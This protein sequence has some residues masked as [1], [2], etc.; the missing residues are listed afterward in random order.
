MSAV[1]MLII[2]EQ[3]R[4]VRKNALFVRVQ[5]K[6][7][8][9]C[10]VGTQLAA[11]TVC[12]LDKYALCARPQLRKSSKFLQLDYTIICMLCYLIY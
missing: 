5:I 8:L 10:H 11:L 2:A 9:L 12:L 1:S 4:V 3:T 7:L 6:M